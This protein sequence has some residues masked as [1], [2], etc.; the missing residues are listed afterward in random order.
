M[1]APGVADP[2]VS[3]FSAIAFM[4]IPSGQ[5]V[6]GAG[7]GEDDPMSGGGGAGQGMI[8]IP[9][10]MLPEGMAAKVKQG[11][12]LIFQVVGPADSEGDIPVEYATEGGG[13]EAS[14]EPWEDEFRE[15]MSPQVGSSGAPENSEPM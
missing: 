14:K 3:R 12:K 7:A 11:D 1:L 6:Q 5:T 13:G 9:G 10:D 8:H 4:M 15:H 2:G